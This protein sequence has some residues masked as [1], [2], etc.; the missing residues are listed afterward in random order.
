MHSTWRAHSVGSSSKI[1]A[2][3]AKALLHGTGW[4]P[5]SGYVGA[6][7]GDKKQHIP[8]LL[9]NDGPQGFRCN[10]LG[11]CPGGTSTQFP[12]GLTVAATWDANATKAWGTAMGKEFYAKGGATA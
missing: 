5:W 2:S 6:T 1:A 11:K 3:G 8:P 10:G 7:A 12:S 4:V 9:L